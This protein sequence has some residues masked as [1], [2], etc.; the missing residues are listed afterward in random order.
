[1]VSKWEGLGRRSRNGLIIWVCL[2]TLALAQGKTTAPPLD[3]EPAGGPRFSIFRFV[4]RLF[5]P[6]LVKDEIKLKRYIRDGRFI[7][8][9]RYYGDPVAVDAIFQK[10]VQLVDYNIHDALLITVFATMDH[11]RVGVK[12][13]LLGS[14]FLPLTGESDSSFRERWENL[15]SRLYDGK[16][17]GG[18][19]DKDKLQ[20]FFGSA[21]ITYALRSS[22]SASLVGSFI[23]WGEGVFIIGG[24]SDWRDQ[25]AN[26]QGRLFGR[27]LG[28]DPTVLPSAYLCTRLAEQ[29]VAE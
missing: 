12:I 29:S 2:T 11:R 16:D 21:F 1:M 4:G 18:G 15:P 7:K 6:P 20:H 22:A 13:P 5:L 25:R 28:E 8:I 3:Y 17:A 14:L 27:S 19:D 9:R 24:H 10:A 23:E 26:E